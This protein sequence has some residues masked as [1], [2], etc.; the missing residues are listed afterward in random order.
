MIDYT[1]FI[2][3]SI[4]CRETGQ[5]YIG[6][7][8]NYNQRISDHFYALARKDHGNYLLQ[9]AY[10]EY[11]RKAFTVKILED[12]IRAKDAGDRERYW[13]KRYG[14]FGH[15]FNL[16]AGGGVDTNGLE[17]PQYVHEGLFEEHYLEIFGN[18]I[19]C[20]YGQHWADW[21]KFKRS[22]DDE[23]DA[24]PDFCQDC[25]KKQAAKLKAAREAYYASKK[26]KS[27]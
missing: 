2:V 27:S 13:I 25:R 26:N 8:R 24:R 10:D 6:I 7:T 12:N 18:E 1:L 5:H 9:V 15:G 21:K 17:S 22:P 20:R 3:Y 14:G 4:K 11:G 16:N 23:W 19:W